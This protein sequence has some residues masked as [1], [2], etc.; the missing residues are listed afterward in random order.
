M[1]AVTAI[2]WAL[3]CAF[4]ALMVTGLLDW[5]A[6]SHT[7]SRAYWW[8]VIGYRALIFLVL[9]LALVVAVAC[10]PRVIREPMPTP[11]PVPCDVDM[12]ARPEP[13]ARAYADAPYPGHATAM[14]SIV[15]SYREVTGYATQLRTLLEG[16]A[17]ASVTGPR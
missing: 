3:L 15:A 17:H 14:R 7:T 6:V 2:E 11:V 4:F 5:H 1:A 10:S 13:P 16:C 8:Q 12:P 9:L